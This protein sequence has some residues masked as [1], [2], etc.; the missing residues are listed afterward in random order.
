MYSNY[1]CCFFVAGWGG[2]GGG[3]L[4]VFV[5]VVGVVLILAFVAI[6]YICVRWF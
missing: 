6:L 5:Y 1:E 3:G 2:G 4:S